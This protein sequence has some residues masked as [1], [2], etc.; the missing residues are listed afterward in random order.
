MPAFFSGA[1]SSSHCSGLFCTNLL[2]SESL[3]L[4]RK[5]NYAVKPVPRLFL[6]AFVCAMIVPAIALFYRHGPHANPTT[7]AFTFL[8]TA[9]IAGQLS[10]RA[11]RETVR[12]NQRRKEIER[13]YAFSQRLLIVESVPE[14]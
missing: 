13:L 12:A 10:E 8:L 7:V 1:A 9:V 4:S 2:S 14:L 6:R 11:R 3:A 5:Y